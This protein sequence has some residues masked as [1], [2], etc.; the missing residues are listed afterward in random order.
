MKRG[1]PLLFV[2]ILTLNQTGLLRAQYELREKPKNAAWKPSLAF[3]Y[4]SRRINWDANAYHSQLKSYLFSLCVEFEMQGGF[5]VNLLAGYSLTSY[6][7]M[8]F[9]QLPFSVELDAGGLGGYLVGGQVE[10]RIFSSPDF[11][12]ALHGR[13]LFTWGLKHTWQINQLNVTG[14]AEGKPYWMNADIGPLFTYTGFDYFYPYLYVN[15]TNFLGKFRM[16]EFI[17]S[18]EGSEN[19]KFTVESNFGV[20]IGAIYELSDV[21]SIKGEARFIPY[22]AGID[23]G[24]LVN[25]IYSVYW[26]R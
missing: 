12:V 26:R 5:L 9:R 17:Q 15:Y 8:V 1:F 13:F 7:E 20:S 16:D 3:E 10:K 14:R 11:E 4:L 19:K 24:F 23:I 22:R 6:D 21:F 2:L 18:L 25:A